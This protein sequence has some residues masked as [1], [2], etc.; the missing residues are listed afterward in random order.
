MTMVRRHALDNQ[1]GKKLEPRWHGPMKAV[2]MSSSGNSMWVE[3]LHTPG[4]KRYQVHDLK[5][6]VQ[7]QEGGEWDRRSR[8]GIRQ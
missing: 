2:R 4:E 8:D 7:R 5:V 3:K 6:C 1:K